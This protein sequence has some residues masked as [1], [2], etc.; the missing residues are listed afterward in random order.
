MYMPKKGLVLSCSTKILLPAQFTALLAHTHTHTQF[1][2]HTQMQPLSLMPNCKNRAHALPIKGHVREGNGHKPQNPV[3][4]KQQQ[5]RFL[6]SFAPPLMAAIVALSPI[7]NPPVSLGQTIEVQKGASLFR[8]TCIGC[9]DAGGNIIQPGA[10]LFLKD[11]QRNGA[12]TEEEIY[13]ITYY[14]KGRMPGFGENCTPRGQ[15]TFGARLQ[16]EEIKL[17]AE[18]VKSQADEGWTNIGSSED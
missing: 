2:P 18:F 5:V 14:G 12:D 10:T 6:H 9:H 4:Q 8:R 15:C 16:E 1:Y 3:A 13:R 7:F 17:L 11:L